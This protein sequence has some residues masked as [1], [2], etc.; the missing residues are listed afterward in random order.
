[1]FKKVSVFNKNSILTSVSCAILLSLTACSAQ[2]PVASRVSPVSQGNDIRQVGSAVWSK[3]TAVNVDGLIN[4]PVPEGMSRLIFIRDSRNAPLQTSI[5]VGVN[6]RFLESIQPGNFARTMVC[7]GVSNLSAVTTGV[8]TNNLSRN[9]SSYQLASGQT[10]FFQIEADSVGNARLM[11]L[12]LAQGRSL[13]QGK[14]LQDHQVNRVVPQCEPQGVAPVLTELNI[15]FKTDKSTVAP[16]YYY[17]IQRVAEFMQQYPTTVINLS[18]YADS[19]ASSAYNLALS[20]RR[21]N[22]VRAVLIN[23]FGISPNRITTLAYGESRAFASNKT[24]T[25]RKK[26]RRVVATIQ[27]R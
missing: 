9:D 26:N 12:T 2:V 27:S 25:G 23:H 22:A 10:Y 24:A 7:S 1:M 15:F 6:N 14:Q 18:G 20:Q 19:R 5:N 13:M 17:D 21:A 8:K 3:R 11:P 16:I 4:T